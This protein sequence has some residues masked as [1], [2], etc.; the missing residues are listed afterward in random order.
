IALGGLGGILF[1]L[2]FVAQEA[3]G[4]MIW[5]P[6]TEFKFISAK[7]GGV[8]AMFGSIA[9]LALMPWVDW[10]KVR[11]SRFRP[12]YRIALIV[13][14]VDCVVLGI[15]GAKPAEQPWV[16]ISQLATLYYFAFF[17]VILPL[18]SRIEKESK[19]PTS[20]YAS[21]IKKTAVVALVIGLLCAPLTNKAVAA[22]AAPTPP[23]QAWSFDGITGTF[24]KAAMQR[25]YQVYKEV[26]SACHSMDRI[27]YRNLSAL[28]YNED[29][30]KAIASEYTVMDGPNDEGDMFERAAR[31]SDRFKS[32]FD[33]KNAARYA[34]NGALPPDLSLIVKARHYGADYIHALLT[35]YT[36]A[37]E[38]V[39]L[40]AGMSYNTYFAGHQ[41]AMAAPLMDDQIAYADN[42]PA[43]VEQMSSD[44]TTFLA[45]ASEPSQDQRKRMGIKVVLFLIFLS[46]LMYLVK[47]KVWKD[48][49]K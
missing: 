44:V 39:T 36:D 30:I 9:A 35:G 3:G 7:L 28:G 27:A 5:L 33:N 26:C 49:E 43:T 42:T 15:M 24:D 19:L 25:G 16:I 21:V 46:F 47:K 14:L 11:S 1:V 12:L 45:W 17:F 31:P 38:G 29:Q 40:N 6:F 34:N 2:G 37:P 48:I 8:L 18:L 4:N 13:F 20:I 10:H 22:D 41:I 32:P 23:H